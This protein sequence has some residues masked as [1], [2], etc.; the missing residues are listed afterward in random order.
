MCIMYINR[1]LHVCMSISLRVLTCIYVCLCGE[2]DLVVASRDLTARVYHRVC[3]RKMATTVLSG[4]RGPLVGAFFALVA[5]LVVIHT[6][7]ASHTYLYLYRLLRRRRMQMRPRESTPW[8][9]TEGFSHGH[10]KPLTPQPQPL[11]RSAP[12]YVHV[13]IYFM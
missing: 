11:R 13:C 2:Q 8:P 3:S 6:Q 12:L 7:L 5:F 9:G 1:C 4:H 10:S